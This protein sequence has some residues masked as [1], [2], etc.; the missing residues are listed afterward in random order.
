MGDVF[1]LGENRLA[2]G[3]SGARK[4]AAGGRE[5]KKGGV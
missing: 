1:F 2:R 3:R 4:L 5:V